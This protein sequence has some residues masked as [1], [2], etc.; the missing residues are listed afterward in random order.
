MIHRLAM[1][2]LLWVSAV[3]IIASICQ[4]IGTPAEKALTPFLII[5]FSSLLLWKIWK[6][7]NKWGL[8]VG[9]F[10]LMMIVFQSHL[11]WESVTDP[12][13]SFDRSVGRFILHEIPIFFAGTSCIL[14]RFYT[15]N[16][17]SNSKG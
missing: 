5:A 3:G 2:S 13:L 7:P 1:I 14:L 9:I 17:P 8:G 11:W 10:F 15:P 6:R 12:A 16:D 4:P